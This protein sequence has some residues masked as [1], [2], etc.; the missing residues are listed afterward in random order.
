MDLISNN[1]D[2]RESS[3]EASGKLSEYL[4]PPTIAKALKVS[5]ETVLQWI[6]AGSLEAS[7]LAPPGAKRPRY[8]VTRASLE[9]FLKAR[10]VVPDSARAERNRPLPNTAQNCLTVDWDARWAAEWAAYESTVRSFHSDARVL[11]RDHQ[12]AVVST[13]DNGNTR[14]LS[15]A[16]TTNPRRAWRSAASR[17]ARIRST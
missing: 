8:L 3:S 17:L 9:E 7:N 14:Y 2:L 13:D 10:K 16:L 5:R 15:Q 12:F 6:R 4:R 11:L 1:I